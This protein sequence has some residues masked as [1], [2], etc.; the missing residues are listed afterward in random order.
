MRM[1]PFIQEKLKSYEGLRL[2]AYICPTGHPT[3]GWGH[4]GTVTKADV[5]NKKRITTEEAQRLFEEDVTK[6]EEA[7]MKYIKV[8][9]NEN[10]FGAL[11]MFVFNI[12][13]T[14]F[15]TSTILKLINAG[16]IPAAAE[17]FKRWNK[18]TVDG[19]FQTVPGLVTR[20]Q[21]EREAFER[22]ADGSVTVAADSMIKAK[23][24]LSED[25]EKIIYMFTAKAKE[26]LE[27]MLQKIPID[28]QELKIADDM[29]IDIVVRNKIGRLQVEFNGNMII[30]KEI[31]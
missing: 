7:L 10:Q 11:T 1:P 8:P 29:Q 19:V 21:W 16:N 6:T 24:A 15:K 30:D 28:G 20:R 5:K 17:Q 14:A 26:Y 12:G 22:P 18:G 13:I 2:Q 9:L 31:A 4:T 23:R 25:A 3:I 27:T